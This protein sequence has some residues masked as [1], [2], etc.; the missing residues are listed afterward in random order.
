MSNFEEVYNQEKLKSLLR[1][2]PESGLLFW[3]PRSSHDFNNP[4]YYKTWNTRFSNKV[5]GHKRPDGY[6]EIGLGG[7]L[8]LCHRAIWCLVNGEWPKFQ[9]DHINGV[10][11]DNRLENLRE[12]TNKD[13]SKNQKSRGN[14]SGV[15]GVYKRKDTGKFVSYIQNLEGKTEYLGQ[16]DCLEQASAVRKSKEQEY[17]YHA[18]HGRVK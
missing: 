7:K 14:S 6:V 11:F 9:I 2:E 10:E 8:I 18:N 1:Y 5:A 15:V 17:S 4:T 16:Y 3:N 13:N 12:V